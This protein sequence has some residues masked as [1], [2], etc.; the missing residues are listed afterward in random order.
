MKKFGHHVDEE[1]GKS[2]E[3]EE[4]KNMTYNILNRKKIA[5]KKE[6]SRRKKNK[7]IRRHR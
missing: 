7:R 1:E 2:N 3:D 6:K 4:S 5:R